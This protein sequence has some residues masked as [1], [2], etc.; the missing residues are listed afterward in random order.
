MNKEETAPLSLPGRMLV[1]RAAR[2]WW[3]LLLAGVAWLVVG[4][5]VLRADV[6]SLATV[7]LLLG[8]VFVTS[9]V[10]EAAIGG[11]VTG[12]WKILHYGIA[13][14][15]LLGG[16]WAFIRPI[17]TF[18]ALASMLGLI[19]IFYGAFEI[20]RGIGAR[21]E[22]PYWW[23]SLISGVLLLLLA[24]WVSTSDPEATIARRSLLILFWVG[25]VA[26]LRGFSEIMLAFGV[27]HLA[28]APA[29]REDRVAEAEEV[30]TVVPAQERRSMS[31]QDSAPRTVPRA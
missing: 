20:T 9:G 27:R 2:Y 28:K 7:G 19:L 26:L 6:T 1:Q 29:G 10:N 12:G 16:L 31:E 4:W 3:T 22:T 5:V 23:A 24:L 21:G 15:F 13:V 14:V 30:P 17:D 11:M 25:T 18:F 8:I